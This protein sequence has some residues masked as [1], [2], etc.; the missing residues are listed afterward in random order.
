MAGCWTGLSK[1]IQQE[2]SVQTGPGVT[3]VE[4]FIAAALFSWSSS[5]ETHPAQLDAMLTF[6]S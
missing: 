5:Y 4:E 6:C 1:Q 3:A 2:S